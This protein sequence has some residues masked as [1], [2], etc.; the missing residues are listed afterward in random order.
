M[1]LTDEDLQQIV[2]AV[3]ANKGESVPNLPEFK[4]S[5]FY[6]TW[7]NAFSALGLTGVIALPNTTFDE[8]LFWFQQWGNV[9]TKNY[10]DFKDAVNNTFTELDGDIK[11][12]NDDLESLHNRDTELEKELNDKYNNIVANAI[13]ITPKPIASLAALVAL[14]PNGSQDIYVAADNG[15]KYMW[16]DGKWTDAGAYQAA[17]IGDHVITSNNINAISLNTIRDTYTDDKNINGWNGPTSFNSNNHVINFTGKN[18]NS[19]VL[20]PVDIPDLPSDLDMDLVLSF[21]YQTSR[22]DSNDK[23]GILLAKDNGGFFNTT[24]KLAT[25]SQSTSVKSIKSYVNLKNLG[26]TGVPTHFNLLLSVGTDITVSISNLYFNKTGVKND[27]EHQLPNLNSSEFINGGVD[28]NWVYNNHF[29]WGGLTVSTQILNDNSLLITGSLFNSTSPNG[30]IYFNVNH[31]LSKDMYITVKATQSVIDNSAGTLLLDP[32]GAFIRLAPTYAYYDTSL[33]PG[34]DIRVYKLSSI[35]RKNLGFINKSTRL[36]FTLSNNSWV[37]IKEIV[38]SSKPGLIKDSETSIK[39]IENTP[40]RPEKTIGQSPTLIN[41]AKVITNKWYDGLSYGTLKDSPKIVNNSILKSVEVYSPIDTTVTI[42]IATLDQNNLMVNNTS[43]ISKE[44]KKGLNI[45]RLEKENYT[46]IQGQKV[47]IN[48]DNIGVYETKEDLPLFSTALVQDNTHEITDG[49]YNGFAYYESPYIIPFNY[50]VVEEAIAN[51]ISKVSEKF[52]SMSAD[53][54]TLLPLTKNLSLTSPLG[55]KFI[56]LV[57][58]NGN[59]I[60]KSNIPNDVV[61]MGNSL[62]KNWGDFG[63]AASSYKND[64]FAL[65]KNYI[66]KA[67]SNAKI[68]RLGFGDWEGSTSSDARETVFNQQLKPFLSESTDLV[69]I[70]LGDN[71]N[72]PEKNATFSVDA[73][74]LITNIKSI[75]PKATVIWVASWYLSYPDII[76]SVE[77]ACADTNSIFVNIHNIPYIS[78]T[79]SFIGAVQTDENGNTRTITSDG[80]ASHPGD[81]GH[82]LISEAVI[83]NFEF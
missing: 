76:T 16:F 13:V 61:I 5:K 51:K 67:N 60:T 82:Q 6:A 69:I 74:K 62:T 80:A 2:D 25:I 32:T 48:L 15:H 66:L 12:I 17:I 14:L 52:D 24:A 58:D 21:D 26:Y 11:K 44:V 10:N 73:K 38:V 27:L 28:L 50:T 54:E 78:G 83:K 53:I 4:Q 1:A 35:Q 42:K 70:Q 77:S 79:S 7:S 8:W 37:N 40:I 64:W 18:G 55:K 22:Q 72:L 43:T 59:I 47:F 23:Y 65:T 75:S 19:G 20:I 41:N 81:L 56:L 36:L 3:N 30:G 57:D 39:L 29:N 71:I 31:D 45:L 68:T 33:E 63:L 34:I 9:F 46:I 49:T